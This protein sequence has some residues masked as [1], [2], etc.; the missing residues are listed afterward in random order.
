MPIIICCDENRETNNISVEKEDSQLMNR[1]IMINSKNGNDNINIENNVDNLDNKNSNENNFLDDINNPKSS[2][3]Y[4]D[5]DN[6]NF[7][8]KFNY[9]DNDLDY[10]LN[11]WLQKGEKTLKKRNK[12]NQNIILIFRY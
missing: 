7:T 9:E 11:L 4:K 3:F 12:I 5:N 2:I 1:N 6:E 10:N 8:V